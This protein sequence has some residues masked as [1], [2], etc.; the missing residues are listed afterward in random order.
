MFGF[1][2]GGNGRPLKGFDWENEE[3]GAL[4]LELTLV[5]SA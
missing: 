3:I 5:I 1:Y 2:F 4:P